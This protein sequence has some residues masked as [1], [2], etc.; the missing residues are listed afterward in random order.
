MTQSSL[1]AWFWVHKWT[2]LIST[3]FLL[4]LCLTGLPLI[5]SA[6][7]D[8]ALDADVLPAAGAAATADIDGMVARALAAQP[9]QLPISLAFL[10]D[11]PAVVVQTGETLQTPFPAQRRQVF[12]ARTGQPVALTP[13]KSSG[14]VYWTLELHKGLLIDLPGTLFLGVIGLLFLVAIVSGVVLYAPFMRKFAFGMVRKERRARTLW[15]DLHN[16]LGIATLLWLLV[17]GGTGVI[18]TLH[19]PIAAQVRDGIVRMVASYRDAPAPKRLASLDA[20]LAAAREAAPGMT[21]ASLFFPGVPF[22][23]P[24]HFGVYLRGDTPVTSRMLTAVLV[25]AETGQVTDRPEMPWYAKALFVSQPLHFGDYG[26]MVLKI[27]WAVF[28]L[29]AIVVLGSGLYLWWS[30]RK[31]PLAAQLAEIESGGV[32]DPGMPS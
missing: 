31:A 32:V 1:R 25:D 27:V 8:Q 3:A 19:D 5:F 9:G 21:V 12:D 28:D 20:V 18:N 17:V 4:L 29:V 6:E 24:H 23:T 30:R 14:F 10:A 16:L 7:I 22:S 13:P 11:Q 2:S 26:G 15:L